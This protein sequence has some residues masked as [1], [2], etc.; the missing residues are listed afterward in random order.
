MRKYKRII[1]VAGNGITRAPMAAE[2]F[3][4]LCNEDMEILSRGIIVAF[5]EPLNQKTEA[6]MI[7]NGITVGDFESKQI[8]N[9][10]ITEDTI[11]FVMEESKRV[12]LIEELPNATEENTFVL[13]SF[14]GEELEIMDPY[15][16][17]LQTYGIC[18]EMLKATLTKVAEKLEYS[19]DDET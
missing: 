8:T 11:L 16:G 5:P 15:G 10:E 13:T 2:I 4:T 3:K 6:V 12:K 19:P 14:V 7:S 17:S 1:F 18:F 9:D